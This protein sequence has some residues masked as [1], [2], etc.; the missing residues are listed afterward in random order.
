MISSLGIAD[1][2][3]LI[4]ILLLVVVVSIIDHT[5]QHDGRMALV[6]LGVLELFDQELFLRL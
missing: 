5:A 1:E 3:A 2:L 6:R 4:L